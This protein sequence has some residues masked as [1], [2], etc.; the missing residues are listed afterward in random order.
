MNQVPKFSIEKNTSLSYSAQKPLSIETDQFI[1]AHQTL[2]EQ[3]K[4]IP[5]N[6]DINELYFDKNQNLLFFPSYFSQDQE[7]I[8]IKSI[9]QNL[10]CQTLKNLIINSK[11]SKVNIYT[12]KIISNSKSNQFYLRF[13]K[14][15]F[16]LDLEKKVIKKINK[17]QNKMSNT[18]NELFGMY[19]NRLICDLGN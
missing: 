6:K 10:Q 16:L 1:L 4:Q 14:S 15:I 19:Q 12:N 18:I 3:S 5:N 9:S 17:Y 13:F 8:K 2:K 11:N 7:I